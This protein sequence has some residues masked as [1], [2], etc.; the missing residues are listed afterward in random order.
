MCA[1]FFF[2]S[3][4]TGLISLCIGSFAGGLLTKK[5]KLNPRRAL[6]LIFVASVITFIFTL[7]AMF[8]SCE[9]PV[10]QNWDSKSSR[11]K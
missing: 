9:P 10:V 2:F 7:V 6:L 8:L 3:A 5:I 11:Y 4:V 1:V